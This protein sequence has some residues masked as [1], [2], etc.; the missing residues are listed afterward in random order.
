MLWIR[1]DSMQ[2]ILHPKEASL[3]LVPHKSVIIYNL[4]N[5]SLSVRLQAY[6]SSF[7]D[8]DHYF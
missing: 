2:L 1:R 7:N 6:M 5:K 3:K 4:M 8:Y